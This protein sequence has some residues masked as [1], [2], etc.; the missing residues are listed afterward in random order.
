[1]LPG[2]TY[3]TNASGHPTKFNRR[4]LNIVSQVLMTLVLYN[5]RPRSHTSSI[6]M[7]TACFLYYIIDERQ[8]DM[9][10]IISNEMKMIS[11]RGRPL[12]NKTPSTLAFPSL[13]MRLCQKARVSP[14]SEAHETIDGEVND[15]HI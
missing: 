14:S 3:V 11:L 10:R 8:V 12:N 9:E 6:P 5:I 4:D 7:D 2:R 13:I 15:R 1:M